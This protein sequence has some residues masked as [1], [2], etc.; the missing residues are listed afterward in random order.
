MNMEKSHRYDTLVLVTDSFPFGGATEPSFVKPEIEALGLAF[1]R[2]VIMPTIAIGPRQDVRLP[3]N[4]GISEFWLDYPEWKHRWLRA[5]RVFTP[6]VLRSVKDDVSYRGLTLS[7]ASQAFSCAIVKWM[8]LQALDWNRTLFYTFWFDLATC[9]L[10]LTARKYPVNFITRAHGRHDV[11]TQRVPALRQEAVSAS[12]GVFAVGDAAA[13]HLRRTMPVMAGKIKR[14]YIGSAKVCPEG[15]SSPHGEGENCLTFLSLARVALEKRVELNYVLLRALAIARPS[16][17]IKWIHVGDGDLMPSLKGRVA[18][19]CPENLTVE[20]L[21]AMDNDSAQRIFM[22]EPIDW[23][24]LLSTIEGLP[25][26]ACES[27]SYGVPVVATMI[28]GTDEALDDDCA[29]LLAPDPRPEEF[30]RGILPYVDGRSRYLAMRQAALVRWQS[31][32]DARK[33]RDEFVNM[34]AGL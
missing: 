19:D 21:G 31:L 28:D 16:L 34:I 27:L 30:V 10:A 33:L 24:M 23:T 18:A 7:V 3:E 6:S 22:S 9:G 13:G 32:F 5:W 15:V 25:I 29:L 11:Y 2:V 12:L 17:M 1:R 20:L 8:K 14:M 26:A 4:V